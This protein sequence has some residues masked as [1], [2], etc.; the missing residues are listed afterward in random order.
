MRKLGLYG[1]A[2]DP[3]HKGHTEAA[4]CFKSFMSLDK[5][6]IIPAFVSPLKRNNSSPAEHRMNMCRLAFESIGDVSDF[7]ILKGGISYTSDTIAHFHKL[8][9]DCEIYLLI[10]TDQFEN[11][12][13]WHEVG[14]IFKNAIIT[15][16]DRNK[17]F[18]EEKA[19]EYALA[20]AQILRLQMD[21]V[22]VS[23]TEI[24][25][26]EKSGYLNPK[27][28]EYIEKNGLYNT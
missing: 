15:V 10:G 11:L 20:G 24:R 13:K 28:K 5:L 23:S 9:P 7:E 3:P 8:Y 4:Q 18:P 6:F 14:Y 21:I 16:A 1:G 17:V 25:N 19:K 2:F 12:N 22:N 26:S 27:V